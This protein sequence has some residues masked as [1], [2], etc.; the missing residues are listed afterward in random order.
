[1]KKRA[2][3]R[4]KP[5][6]CEAARED[7]ARVNANPIRSYDRLTLWRVSMNHNLP[8]WLLRPQKLISNPKQISGP[9]FA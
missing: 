8:E 5:Q 3:F 1:L 7:R 4:L 2:G 6:R 9:L